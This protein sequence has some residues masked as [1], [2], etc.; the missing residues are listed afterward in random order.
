MKHK[1]SD[2]TISSIIFEKDDNDATRQA[3]ELDKILQKNLKLSNYTDTIKKLALFFVVEEPNDDPFWP[4]NDKWIEEYQF[5][6]MYLNVP[7]YHKYL[8]AT[9]T[10]AKL[11]VANLFLKGIKTYLSKRED[12]DHEKL[13]EDMRQVFDL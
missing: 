4:D 3:K 6:N 12:I 5:Y 13:Y 1:V 2:F 9:S 7:D 11:I 8:K 10:D